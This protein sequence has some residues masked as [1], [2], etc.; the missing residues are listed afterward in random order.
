MAYPPEVLLKYPHM[1]P[2]EN[3]LWSLWMQKFGF[4]FDAFDYDVHLGKG[5]PLKPEWPEYTKRQAKWLTQRR[6]DAVGY[7]RDEVWLFEVKPYIGASVIGQ[8]T[9]YRDLWILEKGL[10]RRLQLAVVGR[11][12]GYDLTPSLEKLMVKVYLV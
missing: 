3:R 1:T 8:L 7:K 9:L 2:Q 4:R 12:M 5:M 6:V 11:Y 10:P